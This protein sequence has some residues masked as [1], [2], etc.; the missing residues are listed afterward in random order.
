MKREITMQKPEYPDYLEYSYNDETDR[1]VIAGYMHAKDIVWGIDEQ[2]DMFIY[3]KRWFVYR[4][5][6]PSEKGVF[7][8]GR[9]TGYPTKEDAF[10]FLDNYVRK[11]A[12]GF[13]VDKYE[14]KLS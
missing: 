13:P 14:H 7:G 4:F 1:V 11:F 9:Y 10:E 6:M 12:T 5:D 8:I 3:R 2:H